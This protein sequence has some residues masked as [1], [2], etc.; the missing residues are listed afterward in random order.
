[1]SDNEQNKRKYDSFYNYEQSREEYIK[2]QNYSI[3]GFP[4]PLNRN[5]PRGFFFRAINHEVIKADLIQLILTEPGERLMMPSYGTGLRKLIFEAVDPITLEQAN[6]IISEAIRR[7][8]PRIVVKRI[9]VRYGES[10]KNLLN[11]ISNNS[12]NIDLNSIIIRI[13]YA[14]KNNLDGIE[15]LVF[16]L[17]KS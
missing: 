15:S 4:F 2:S 1:M 11:H 5:D 8:E 14:L 17:N 6:S 10:D 9:D 7:W 16:K 13:D 3:K 12:D